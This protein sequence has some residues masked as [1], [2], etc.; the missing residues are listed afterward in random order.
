MPLPSPDVAPASKLPYSERVERALPEGGWPAE[1][2][3]AAKESAV[4]VVVVASEDPG[5]TGAAVAKI[6]DTLKARGVRVLTVPPDGAI[7]K[8]LA[9]AAL[10][11]VLLL[12]KGGEGA[13]RLWREGEEPHLA[14]AL[15]EL[16]R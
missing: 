1:V 2:A 14:E 16:T 9:P 4:L 12:P 8:A 11:S 10:P 7:G 3:A 15:L 6:G 13:P 5:P